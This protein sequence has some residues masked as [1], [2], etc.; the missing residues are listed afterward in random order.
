MRERK[1]VV[2]LFSKVPEVGRVKTRLSILKD[3]MFLPE[4][5]AHLYHCMLFAVVEIIMA[6][7]DDLES[8]QP[9]TTDAVDGPGGVRDTY[10]LVI[11]TTPES[12]VEVG[13]SRSSRTWVQASTS[14]TT[15]RSSSVGTWAPTAYCRWART[16]PL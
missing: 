8:A 13:I 9:D 2:L 15:T 10:E 7:L 1:N 5:A 4:D 14:I 12:N 16:C 6:A 11:S 3:G